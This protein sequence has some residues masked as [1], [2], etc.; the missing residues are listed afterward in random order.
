MGKVKELN[1][2]NRTYYYFNDI[3]NIK[4]FHSNLL[5]IDKKRYKD[6]DIYYIGYI[7]V[8][9]TGDC[10]NISSVNP[11]HLSVNPV[12]I[13]WIHSATGYFTEKNGQKYL[14]LDLTEKYEE[15]FSGIKKEIETINGRKNLI[16]EKNYARI[17]VNTDDDVPLNKPLK[18]S[19]LTVIIRCVFQESEK[20]YLQIY[21]DECLYEL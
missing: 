11:L 17:G 1:I 12:L 14:I 21:L 6:I 2:K 5:R 7:T 9:K 8:K 13:H 10:K 16:Y 19:T 20:S 4:D 3:I 15:V 18:F